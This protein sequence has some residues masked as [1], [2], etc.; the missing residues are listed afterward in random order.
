MT[1]P[2]WKKWLQFILLSYLALAVTGSFT[3]FKKENLWFANSNAAKLD[4]ENFFL[5]SVIDRSVDLL[6][7][8]T[9]RRPNSFQL[10]NV[11]LRVF[12]L[13]G[14]F[15]AAVLFSGSCYNM[16]NNDKTLVQKNTILLKLRI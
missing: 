11:F 8:Y 6:A 12:V 3:F 9:I 4:T 7:E 15:T 2:V 5:L 1:A 16:F 14:I 13:A 10:R